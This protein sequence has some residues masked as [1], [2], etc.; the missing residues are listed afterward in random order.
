MAVD[1]EHIE[2]KRCDRLTHRAT[3]L[4]EVVMIVSRGERVALGVIEQEAVRLSVMK[5]TC[6][7]TSNG[8]AARR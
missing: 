4:T 8:I 7:P 5:A 3:Q 6:E 2:D 1:S